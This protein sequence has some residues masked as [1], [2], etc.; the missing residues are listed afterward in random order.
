[1]IHGHTHRPGIHR[2]ELNDRDTAY[3]VVLGD[4]ANAPSAAVLKD[5]L[6][7]LYYGDQREELVLTQ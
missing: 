6:I 5:N 3:R 1:M 2:I 7:T 4:W